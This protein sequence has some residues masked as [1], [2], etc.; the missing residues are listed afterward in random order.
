M[1]K[2]ITKILHLSVAI[3]MLLLGCYSTLSFSLDIN[4]N[5][6]QD[7]ICKKLFRAIEKHDRQ[8]VQDYIKKLKEFPYSSLNFKIE[9]HQGKLYNIQRTPLIKACN[10]NQELIVCDL[11]ESGA[12]INYQDSKGWSALMVAAFNNFEKLV[13]LLL[14]HKA[15]TDLTHSNGN[16]ALICAAQNGYKSLVKQL[17]AA[18]AN[19]E[20]CN[21]SKLTP[22]L[23][24]LGKN[25]HSV[26]ALLLKK[27]AL[28]KQEDYRKFVLYNQN[29]AS[30]I[31]EFFDILNFYNTLMCE[32][33]EQENLHNRDSKMLSALLINSLHYKKYEDL[34]LKSDFLLPYVQKSGYALLYMLVKRKRGILN[35]DARKYILY[36]K[37]VDSEESYAY[38][39]SKKYDLE[40]IATLLEK[41]SFITELLLTT[42]LNRVLSADII[43]RIVTFL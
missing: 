5:N 16:T 28:V 9:E 22:L 34:V 31:Q 13:T 7:Y 37:A 33:R 35:P 6:N 40:T 15:R 23:C 41:W 17:L 26:V 12:D 18:G 30:F 36:K 21:T 25:Q 4:L 20:A 10:E 11:L 19:K 24:A 29:S 42:T 8:A 27:G 38:K 43:S 2:T 1:I 14:E 39:A 3:L 32:K